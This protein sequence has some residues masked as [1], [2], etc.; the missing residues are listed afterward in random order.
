M[1][2]H[3]CAI[4]DKLL[5]LARCADKGEFVAAGL[6]AVHE[7]PPHGCAEQPEEQQK[8]LILALEALF[9]AQFILSVLNWRHCAAELVGKYREGMLQK[10]TSGKR[11]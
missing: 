9:S 11:P 4:A 7:H 6:Q 5:A 1:N 3:D 2:L 8:N 10:V